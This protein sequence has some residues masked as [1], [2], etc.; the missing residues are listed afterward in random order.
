[1][2]AKAVDTALTVCFEGGWPNALHRVLR[3]P[4]IEQWESA[5]CPPV[6]KRPGEGEVVGAI[7]EMKVNRYSFVA[8]LGIVTGPLNDLCLYAGQSVEQIKDIPAA[9]TL[10][11]RLWAECLA[12]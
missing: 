8:P 5:G 1:M 6:G 2:H 4:V 9:A 3:N 11:E 10:V 12:A 7:G